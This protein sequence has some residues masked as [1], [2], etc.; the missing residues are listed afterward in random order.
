MA[1][2]CGRGLSITPSIQDGGVIYANYAELKAWGDPCNGC[3]SG[4][5]GWL[6]VANGDNVRDT[7]SKMAA[8]PIHIKIF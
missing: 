2:L 4:G 5:L 1:L 8:S 6:S 7:R 3:G